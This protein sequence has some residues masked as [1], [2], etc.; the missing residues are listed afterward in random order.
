MLLESLAPLYPPRAIVLWAVSLLYL[1]GGA[2]IRVR[3]PFL[4]YSVSLAMILVGGA[5]FVAANS[6]VFFPQGFGF[7]GVSLLSIILI[8][9]WVCGMWSIKI[10]VDLLDE[11]RELRDRIEDLE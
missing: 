1:F 2:Y 4:H 8:V 5:L 7:V 6:R 11:F 10:Q 9:A 3:Y